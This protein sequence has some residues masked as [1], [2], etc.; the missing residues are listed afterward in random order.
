MDV[1]TNLAL[2]FSVVLLAVAPV[3]ALLLC[4]LYPHLWVMLRPR[5]AAAATVPS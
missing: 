4:A 5:T 3:G 1:L 2:G